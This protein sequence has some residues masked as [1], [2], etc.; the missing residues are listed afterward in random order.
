MAVIDFH[1]HI[2]RGDEY[3]RSVPAG[4]KA[5]MGWGEPGDP[6]GGAWSREGIVSLLEDNGVDYAVALAELGYASTILPSN[7]DVAEFCQDMPCLIPFCHINPFLVGRPAQVLERYVTDL[8]FRGLKLHP[9]FNLYYPNDSL[10]YPVYA[11]AQELGIPVIVHTGASALASSRLKYGD[12]IYLD[13]V[14]VDFPHLKIVQAH[15]GRGFWHD[16]AL[17]LTRLHENLYLDVSGLPTERLLAYFPD[18]ER[19]ADKVLFGSDWPGPSLGASIQALRELPL[20]QA[21]KDKILGG[22][23]ARLL[24]LDT[25]PLVGVQRGH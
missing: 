11:K 18:L 8:G 19:N 20:S 3:L 13:D 2:T 25:A 24:G 5:I 6:V 7:E 15:G 14:A 9:A 1:F 4:F 12:P 10:V 22:N 16:R 21:A 17:F 23:A